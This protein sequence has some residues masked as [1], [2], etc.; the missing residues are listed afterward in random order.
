MKKLILTI[1]L[2]C[3]ISLFAQFRIVM[4][5]STIK[6]GVITLQAEKILYVSSKVGDV[7][8]NYTI[9]S[10]NIAYKI[11]IG[12]DTVYRKSFFSDEISSLNSYITTTKHDLLKRAGI[13]LKVAGGCFIGGVVL[14]SIAP[15]L[16]IKS[17]DN[18]TKTETINIMPSFVAYVLAGG[19][20][21]TAFVCLI[22]SGNNLANVG[23]F[24]SS[25]L[26]YKISTNQAGIC[27]TF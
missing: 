21:L 1:I 5:D 9:N 4:K 6:E 13:N 17:V 8:N 19:L 11:P 25:S 27:F 10:D 15:L 2:I 26:K 23:N 20:N 16:I 3:P 22:S 18:Q 14:Y 12:K 7:K 24:K